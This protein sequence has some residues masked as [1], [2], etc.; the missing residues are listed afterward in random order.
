MLYKI[1]YYQATDSFDELENHNQINQVFRKYTI[2][3]VRHITIEN[4]S[5]P[6]FT[7]GNFISS[8][9]QCGTLFSTDVHYSVQ[10]FISVSF[11]LS[12]NLC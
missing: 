11:F 5:G 7:S 12:N 3:S 4:D 10:N 6:I 1:A 2:T 8:A 9:S